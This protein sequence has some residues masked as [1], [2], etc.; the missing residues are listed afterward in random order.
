[1]NKERWRKIVRRTWRVYGFA[2][3]MAAFA[4]I[5]GC[6]LVFYS[7]HGGIAF[8][9]LPLVFPFALVMLFLEYRGAAEEEKRS[10]KSFALTSL[11]AYFLVSFAVTF[12]AAKA[13]ER[14]FG[15]NLDHKLLWGL[16]TMP[17]GL[18]FSWKFFAP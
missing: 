4:F 6:N 3:V 14:T 7:G 18:P 16:F 15:Y 13:L 2:T 9:I 8:L 10:V 17:F 11:V 5:P 1:M 12:A